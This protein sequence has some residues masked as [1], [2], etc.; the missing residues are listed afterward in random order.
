[1]SEYLS[2]VKAA[3]QEVRAARKQLNQAEKN[4]K[5]QI[6]D[7]TKNLQDAENRI[8]QPQKSFAGIDLYLNHI[9]FQN[10]T[11]ALNEYTKAEVSTSGAVYTT[12]TSKGRTGISVGGALIGGAIAGPLGAV[13]GGVT[14]KNDI[15]SEKHDE[16]N[17]Y[18]NVETNDGVFVSE[19]K[20]SDEGKAR[21]F[22][23]EILTAAK[24]VE[25][26]Y[27]RALRAIETARTDLD[28][29]RRDHQEIDACTAVLRDKE[30]ALQYLIDTANSEEKAALTKRNQDRRK[31]MIIAGI[32]AVCL[33]IGI[34]GALLGRKPAAP[35]PQTLAPTV[36]TREKESPKKEEDTKEET[37]EEAKEEVK[38]E[39]APEA[40]EPAAEAPADG[41]RP[42][43]RAAMESYEAFFD[44]YV[45]FMQSV[46]ENNT[47][48]EV[49]MQYYEYLAKYEDA[50]T[51]LDAI[52]E[53]ELSYEEDLLYLE[54]MNHINQKLL[55]AMQ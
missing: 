30:D 21:S 40:E 5:N 45:S 48:T 11:Y 15:R 51:K 29:A 3:E 4:K 44:E 10:R 43:F 28:T 53:S 32:A 33:L 27:D 50:M 42:E 23:A 22:A 1:M 24:N 18:L 47:S 31:G 54:T 2:N 20:I 46:D 52:D 37:K 55:E 13:V 49:L 6:R 8:S 26:E 17:V 41:V 38:E 12:M 19:V 9:D 14:R 39:A 36:T 25:W 34:F 7:L 35:E 16:R